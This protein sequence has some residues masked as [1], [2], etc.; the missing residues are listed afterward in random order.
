MIFPIL[1]NIEVYDHR[2]N[3]NI[4]S[5]VLDFYYKGIR[6]FSRTEDGFTAILFLDG[7]NCKLLIPF[8]EV[9]NIYDTQKSIDSRYKEEVDEYSKDNWLGI[10]EFKRGKDGEED[11]LIV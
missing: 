11:N 4:V 9:Y 3:S 6:R 10:K 1:V 7:F 2:D 5:T 8:E